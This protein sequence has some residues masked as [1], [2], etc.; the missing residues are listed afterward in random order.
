MPRAAKKIIDIRSL[1]RAHTATCIRTLAGIVRQRSAP[2]S[3]RVFAANSLLDR[4][5][6][7]AEQVHS[8]D[9]NG[10]PIQVIIRQ[11]LEITGETIEEPLVIEHERDT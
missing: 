6:G 1:A 9:G 4:G 5:W 8:G 3:A 2:P 7:K 10:G 11:V